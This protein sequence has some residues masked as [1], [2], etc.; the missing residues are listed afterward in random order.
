L[1]INFI[2]SILGNDLQSLLKNG[3]GNQQ[4]S[5]QAYLVDSSIVSSLLS[6]QQQQQQQ[7]FLSSSSFAL[8]PFLANAIQ[9]MSSFHE[10]VANVSSFPSARA[11][12]VANLPPLP[13]NLPGPLGL[14]SLGRH[15]SLGRQTSLG[16]FRGISIGSVG[17]VI[18]DDAAQ[19]SAVPTNQLLQ[20][21]HQSLRERMKQLHSLLGETEK[22]A[23]ATSAP[24]ASVTVP[25][26]VGSAPLKRSWEE[27]S[28]ADLQITEEA[29]WEDPT[30]KRRRMSGSSMDSSSSG[31]NNRFKTYQTE[32]WSEKFEDLM[33]F[34][35]KQ[36]HCCV[37]HAFQENPSL[38]RWVKRQ[39]YQYKLFISGDPASTLTQER[40][41][42][43]ER[44]GF[45][46]DSHSAAWETRYAELADF[47]RMNGHTNVPSRYENSQLA[48]WVKCQR[49]QYKMRKEIGLSIDQKKKT[50]LSDARIQRLEA[51]G[52]EWELRTRKSD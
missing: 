15:T 38:A 14:T 13:T 36:G 42:V 51:L 7:A 44:I 24:V 6:Q 8:N 18:T 34:R 3:S 31:N 45:V 48:T 12:V 10:R 27:P 2:M 32:Q 35:N 37:P 28:S 47:L 22:V 5:N 11:P 33:Q 21:Q 19:S 30:P 40:I 49:R 43:L 26:T 16:L 39:R 17:S 4:T 23:A 9:N 20:E 50:L 1:F 41:D 46:W 29:Q 25:T 52:F